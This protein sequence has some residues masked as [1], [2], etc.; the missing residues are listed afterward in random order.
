M[1]SMS[2][3][4]DETI[5]FIRRES[6]LVV[7]LALA[8]LLVGNVAAGLARPA[9]GSAMG[10]EGALLILAAAIWS[11]VGQLSIGAL[12][13]RPGSSVGEALSLGLARLPKAVAVG[14]LIALAV[15]IAFLPLVFGLTA[16]GFKPVVAQTPT[17]TMLTNLPPWANFYVLLLAVAAFWAAAR[18]LPINM[19]IVDR[20]PRVVETVRQAFAMTRRYAPRILAMLALY[21]IVMFILGLAAQF[22]FG[23]LF[24]IL[25]RV[26]QSPFTGRVL[27][28]LATGLVSMALSLVATV[29]V[30]MFYRRLSN[31]I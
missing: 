12:V 4:W 22:V 11:V 5:A 13:L 17:G 31:G 20:N 10:A 21:L 19:L 15:V 16:S 8:T 14:L 29:F 18:L 6:A 23:S 24:E 28:A 1:I 30:A 3:V 2:S 27:T 9:D 25:G 7:P 26:T